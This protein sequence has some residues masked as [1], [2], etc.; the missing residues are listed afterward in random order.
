MKMSEEEQREYIETKRE[1]KKNST[2]HKAKKA[3]GS[4]WD[5][6]FVLAFSFACAT[7]GTTAT[8]AIQ[9][10]LAG[11]WRNAIYAGIIAVSSVILGSILYIASLFCPPG[12]LTEEMQRKLLE[13][14]REKGKSQRWADEIFKTITGKK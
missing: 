5:Q 3:I 13:Y 6:F 9:L 7:F 11:D 10:L 4:N 2:L 12:S 1:Q 8:I 14:L